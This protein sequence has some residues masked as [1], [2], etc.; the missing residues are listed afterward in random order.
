MPAFDK[1]AIGRAFGRAAQNYDGH[2]ALQRHSG[3]A[4]L[5]KVLEHPGRLVLDA[6]SGTGHFSR[7]LR[8]AGKDVI[9]LDLSTQMLAL[10]RRRQAAHAYL[11]ADIEHLPLADASLDLAFSNLAL[12][13]C[14]DLAGALAELRRVLRPGALVAFST[15][16]EGSLG[17]LQ[18][19]WTR[20]DGTRHTNHFLPYEV[21]A[22]A[23]RGYQATLWQ[24]TATLHFPDLLALLH[25]LKGIGATWL[26]EGRARG[27]LSRTRLAALA[28]AYPATPAGLPL[29][30][31]LVYGVLVKE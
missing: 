2:A 18:Q 3:E 1:T 22:Q 9:A 20:L 17:E 23:C 13:W 8:D 30:Y 29:S 7:R 27:L 19:A 10:A 15:L 5:A 4:L 6:G 31:R 16:E 11:Q 24:E 21:I 26:H 14:E 12:Q 25:S 28:G